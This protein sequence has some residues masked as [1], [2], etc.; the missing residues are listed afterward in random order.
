MNQQPAPIPAPLKAA[1][2]NVVTGT[3]ALAASNTGNKNLAAGVNLTGNL[4]RVNTNNTKAA[5][6][7]NAGVKNINKALVN[8][9]NLNQKLK[10]NLVTAQKHFTTAAI[11]AA[12]NQPIKAANHARRGI[13][14]LKNYIGANLPNM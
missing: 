11:N 14:A 2:G 5:N 10:N 9:T 12:A 8:T 7:F 13:G 6:A 1:V 3:N 4:T